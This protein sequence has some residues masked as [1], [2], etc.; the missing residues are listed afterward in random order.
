MSEDENNN[1]L[2]KKEVL[3]PQKRKRIRTKK[4]SALYIDSGQMMQELIK[5]NDNG[6]ISEE[7]G[8]M[9]LMLST[10]YTS[11]QNF[12]GYSYRDEMI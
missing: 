3:P 10:R 9:F 8:A 6:V 2:P 1:N 7:L 4:G 5:F 12:V 11:K